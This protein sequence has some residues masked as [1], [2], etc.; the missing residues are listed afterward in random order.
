MRAL[1]PPLCSCLKHH[2]STL[3]LPHTQ[4]DQTIFEFTI[5]EGGQWE[6]WSNK[7]SGP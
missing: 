7:V 2:G 1:T 3:D 6:H 4:E 5:S